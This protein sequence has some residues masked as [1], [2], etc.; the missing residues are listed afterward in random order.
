MRQE[1]FLDGRIKLLLGDSRELLPTVGKVDHLIFDPPYE[2]H[3]HDGK[4]KLES[5]GK[6]RDGREWHARPDFASVEG[7]REWA[8]P[9]M[10]G[11]CH[12]WFLAF[13]TPEGIA[14][15]RDAVEGAGIRYKRACFWFKPDSAPQF[16]GQGPAMAVEAFVSAWC[17]AGVSNWNGGGRRNMFQHPTNQAD[18]HGLHPT[19]K[20]LSLMAELVGLFTNQNDLVCDPFMGSGTTMVACIKRGRRG[21]GIERDPKYFDVACERVDFAARQPDMFGEILPTVQT[22][23]LADLDAS[24]EAAE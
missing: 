17:G 10:A 4:S 11:I 13:C 9:M 12:G 6:R 23:I 1:S 15:W 16:N 7:C 14:A 8:V 19:E 20:P 3:M 24:A 21:I 5:S 18:R 22:D 2:K